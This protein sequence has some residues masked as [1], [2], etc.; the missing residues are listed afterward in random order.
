MKALIVSY[1]PRGERSRTRQ[2]VEYAVG[3]L[4]SKKAVVEVLDLAKEVPDLLTPERLASYYRRNYMGEKLA[5]KDLAQLKKMDAMTAQLM[6][7][8]LA[9]VAYPMYNFSQPAIVKA[10]FDSVMQKGK[11]WDFAQ[12]GYAGLMKNRKALI[13]STSGGAYAG[14]LAGMDHSVPLSKLHLSF[15]GFAVEAVT[16]A[17]INRYPEKESDILGQAKAEIQKFLTGFAQ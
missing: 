4:K 15:M 12:G 13:I 14:D 16:G 2:L 6:A 3:F 1:C 9:V 11:T 7:A 5:G 8:D 10:W 17:G